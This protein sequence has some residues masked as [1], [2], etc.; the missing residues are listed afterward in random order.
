MADRARLLLA[1]LEPLAIFLCG[2]RWQSAL[3]R[4][5][6]ETLWLFG[7]EPALVTATS[8]RADE[9]YRAYRLCREYF[10]ENCGPAAERCFTLEACRD[11]AVK[12][13]VSGKYNYPEDLPGLDLPGLADARTFI[14]ETAKAGARAGVRDLL[15][16]GR[17]NKEFRSCSAA[18][19]RP[20]RR[21]CGRQL[22]PRPGHW[23]RQRNTSSICSACWS[24]CCAYSTFVVPMTASRMRWIFSPSSLLARQLACRAGGR[25]PDSPCHERN[26]GSSACRTGGRPGHQ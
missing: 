3:A 23:T 19:C 18:L 12:V 10:T 15:T 13:I 14:E 1:D 11:I 26:A 8:A 21:G 22:G 24:R 25:G 16:A 2:P 4:R 6:N 5:I 9:V 7:H 20:R 17:T